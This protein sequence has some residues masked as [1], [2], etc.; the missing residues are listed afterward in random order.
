MPKLT[1]NKIFEIEP[2]AKTVYRL[3]GYIGLKYPYED[4]IEKFKKEY[5][6]DLEKIVGKNAKKEELRTTEAYEL[7]YSACLEA[8]N[9]WDFW[10]P[11]KDKKYGFARFHNKFGIMPAFEIKER[12]RRYG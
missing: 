11:I 8:V 10:R 7:L 2:K 3:C 1:L 4:N 12:N 5:E 9:C 6:A